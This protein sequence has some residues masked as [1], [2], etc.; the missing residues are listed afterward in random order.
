MAS[1]GSGRSRDEIIAIL[2][3]AAMSGD[4]ESYA[5]ERNL[6]LAVLRMWRSRYIADYANY[7]EAVLYKIKDQI[8]Y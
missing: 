5:K 2:F 6:D 4:V 7:M 3:A 8:D 1:D